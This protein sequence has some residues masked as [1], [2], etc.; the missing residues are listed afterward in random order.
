MTRTINGSSVAI[1]G[2]AGFLG[3]HLT[4]FLI[5][6]R[7]C[8]VVVI[9]NLSVGR[10]EYVHP[11]ASFVW[12]D[13][14]S[15]E[16]RLADIL[17]EHKTQWVFM[18]AAIPFVPD[19]FKRPLHTFE[20]TATSVLRV[21]CAAQEANVAG[22]LVVSSA[23]IYG[24]TVSGPVTEETLVKPHSTYAAAKQAADSLVQVRWH[25]AGVRSL[26][27]R[28]FNSYG[29]RTLNPLVLTTIIDQ[30]SEGPLVKLGNDTTRDFQYC[31]DTVRIWVE[32]LERGEWGEVV[33]CGSETYIKIYDLAR[34]VGNVMGYDSIEIEVDPSRVRPQK[35]EVWH[36]HADCKKLHGLI[37]YR[38]RVSLEDGI[39]RTLDWYTENGG[40][41]FNRSKE[42]PSA[43]CSA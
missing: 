5:E 10:R 37:G 40:W 29:P 30:L 16:D 7:E 12:H 38:E 13:V 43:L 41:D 11:Y 3:S 20:V 21:L 27:A 9:D 33:N 26:A 23:E 2:G 31:D 22:T 1:I 42:H 39:R 32:L 14:L 15:Y 25:E 36:L 17:R 34:M 35:V 19:G 8:Q 4:D 18:V 24:A 6:E 28:Q